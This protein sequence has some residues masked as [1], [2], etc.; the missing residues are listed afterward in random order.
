[1]EFFNTGAVLCVS[2]C[3]C[4]VRQQ[5]E[6]CAVPDPHRFHRLKQNPQISMDCTD[7][8]RFHRFDHLSAGMNV[9]SIMFHF[10]I[11][12]ESAIIC[13]IGRNLWILYKSVESVRVWH[14]AAFV[15]VHGH[16]RNI[17]EYLASQ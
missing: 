9:K 17:H 10:L 2:C 7:D 3:L 13:A 15:Y 11:S 5:Y 16:R 6:R 12:V 8:A 4:G 1:M 14:S